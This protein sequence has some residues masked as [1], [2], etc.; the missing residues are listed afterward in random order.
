MGNARMERPWFHGCTENRWNG[1]SQTPMPRRIYHLRWSQLVQPPRSPPR[2]RRQSTPPSRQP[3]CSFPCCWDNQHLV[4]PSQR[5]S[6]R[7]SAGELPS[8]LASHWRQRISF[9]GYQW[10]YREA[11]SSLTS[12]WRQRISFRGYQWHY[13]EITDEPLE[14]TY[15]FQR[16]SVT[17]QRDHWWAAGDNV[18]LSEDISDTTERS[19]TSH[20][21]QRNS[22]RGYQWHYSEITDEPLETTYLFQR[23]SVT[24]QRDHWRA[25]GGNLSLSE[26]ISDITE[27]SLTSRWRQR[28]SFRGYQWH[29]SEAMKSLFATLSQVIMFTES[30][31]SS[32]LLHPFN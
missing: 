29:Y 5:N 8:S 2:T 15:L 17:L 20:W 25:A 16:I 21:R 19:L 10:H 31:G 28:I 9:R 32:L 1:T 11:P 12:C 18:S 23:I 13:S 4:L 27:R 24:L 14:T 22:F 26:D 3:T 7:N 6:S 30:G